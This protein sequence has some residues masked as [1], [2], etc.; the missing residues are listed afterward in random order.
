MISV[1]H[2]M[3]PKVPYL[4]DLSG[5]QDI[6]LLSQSK[7]KV[8]KKKAAHMSESEIILTSVQHIATVVTDHH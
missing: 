5:Y 4:I 6:G 7:T 2:T 1:A 8:R 3:G